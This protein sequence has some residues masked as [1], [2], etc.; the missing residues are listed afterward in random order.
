MCLDLDGVLAQY[1]GWEGL[2]KIGPPI[3]G[4]LDFAWALA[5]IADIVI[6]TSRCSLDAGGETPTTR[7][8]PRQLRIKVIEWLEKYKFPYADVYAGQGKARAAAFIDDRAVLCTPQKDRQ[9]FE[10]ALE[11]TRSVL[12]KTKNDARAES[13]A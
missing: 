8:S 10:N 6:F 11:A 12:S 4:A 7:L 2:D 1:N 5:Q 3:P 9:A 13:L